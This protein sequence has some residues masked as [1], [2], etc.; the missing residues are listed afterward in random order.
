MKKGME[1]ARPCHVSKHFSKTRLDALHLPWIGSYINLF[2]LESITD[3]FSDFAEIKEAADFGDA[4][5]RAICPIAT[6]GSIPLAFLL[7][8]RGC[9]VNAV[10][11]TVGVTAEISDIFKG[12]LTY[13]IASDAS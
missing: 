6:A 12:V 2:N 4:L 9:L 7:S 10:T 13:G 8:V 5:T 1:L 11:F 3:S